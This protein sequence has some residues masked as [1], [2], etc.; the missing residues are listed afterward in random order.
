[1]A[2]TLNGQDH[3]ITKLG[4]ALDQNG[5]RQRIEKTQVARPWFLQDAQG[6]VAQLK[7]SARIAPLDADNK[8]VIV[9]N[10]D[11]VSAVPDISASAP[12]H[13]QLEESSFPSC[14]LFAN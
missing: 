11:D 2:A 7:Y 14:G 8:G 13:H 3:T 10:L 9:Q 12:L 4:W 5:N 6:W 1:M